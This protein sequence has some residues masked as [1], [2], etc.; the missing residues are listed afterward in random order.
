MIRLNFHPEKCLGCRSCMLACSFRHHKGYSIPN[1]RIKITSST[2]KE[3]CEIQICK[4]CE[5]KFCFEACP[6]EAITI[7]SNGICNVDEEICTGCGLCVDACIYNG[8]WLN[9]NTQIAV[10]CNLCS[11]SPACAE[12]CIPKAI[13]VIDE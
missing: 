1:A 5:E 13:E 3:F 2:G 7:D 9:E 12:V 11:G 8:I 10:K 4:Q 6:F